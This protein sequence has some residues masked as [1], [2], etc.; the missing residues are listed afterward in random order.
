[1][2]PHLNMPIAQST[3]MDSKA[4]C[5]RL[6]TH[7]LPTTLEMVE[8]AILTLNTARG[9]SLQKLKK[10]IIEKYQI[11]MSAKRYTMM[12]TH[13]YTLFSNGTL[14]TVTGRG[15]SG[16]FKIQK[17]ISGSLVKKKSIGARNTDGHIGARQRKI[18]VSKA[19]SN[20]SKKKK[21]VT[22]AN[23]TETPLNYVTLLMAPHAPQRNSSATDLSHVEQ[24]GGTPRSAGTR[25]GRKRRLASVQEPIA[26]SQEF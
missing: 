23:L 16:S 12:K 5:I 24:V 13:L 22:P 4:F 11:E 14:M 1:M 21:N 6:N 19:K 26:A 3:L 2:S 15:L 20:K 25:V 10:Y 9:I 8:E 7:R 17:T 18:G